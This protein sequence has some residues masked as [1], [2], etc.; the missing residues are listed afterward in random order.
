M[1]TLK[2][3]TLQDTSGNTLS[4]V[5]KFQQSTMSQITVYSNNTSSL[6]AVDNKDF[7]VSGTNTNLLVG[8]EIHGHVAASN[9]DNNFNAQYNVGGGSYTDFNYN[10]TNYNSSNGKNMF[11]NIRGDSMYT[12]DVGIFTQ[13]LIDGTWN[14]GQTINVK[15]NLIGETNF[16]MNISQS[17]TQAVRFGRG[18]SKIFFTE[19][20]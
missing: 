10:S 18:V 19:F 16:S 6:V 2:V 15:L 1:S 11:P 9:G 13:F 8:F 17:D 12:G 14:S 4:R 7:V 20:P 5:L 3:N